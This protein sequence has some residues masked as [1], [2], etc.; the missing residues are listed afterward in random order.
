MYKPYL[1]LAISFAVMT[2]ASAM[3][4]LNIAFCPKFNNAKLVLVFNDASSYFL[5]ASSYLLAS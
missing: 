4:P 1:P 2:I 3:A 5:R